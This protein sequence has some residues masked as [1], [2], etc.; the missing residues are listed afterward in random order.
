MLY[1]KVKNAKIVAWME[2]P[3]ADK[4]KRRTVESKGYL[5]EEDI[6][7]AIT[8]YQNLRATGHLIRPDKLEKTYEIVSK[9]QDSIDIIDSG[10]QRISDMEDSLPSWAEVEAN[11]SGAFNVGPQRDEVTKLARALYWV[12]KNKAD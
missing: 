4:N 10:K 9:D 7:P 2:I 5:P 1:G 3:E 12:V 11:V 6:P 8:E